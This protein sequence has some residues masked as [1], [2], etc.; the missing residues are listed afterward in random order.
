MEAGAALLAWADELA[1][2]LNPALVA[3]DK[4]G[5]AARA[6]MR[7]ALKRARGE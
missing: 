2:H 3:M 5:A 6:G 7:L 1:Q 4:R